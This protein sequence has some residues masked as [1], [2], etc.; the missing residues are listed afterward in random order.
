MGKA[1]RELAEEAFSIDKIVDQH[2]KIYE[3]VSANG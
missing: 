1:G 2:L 3:Q